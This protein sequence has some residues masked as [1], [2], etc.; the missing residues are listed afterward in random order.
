MT[1]ELLDSREKFKCAKLLSWRKIRAARFP[2]GESKHTEP[3]SECRSKHT[4]PLSEYERNHT[5][6]LSE[7]ESKH[8]EPLSKYE[9]NHTESLSCR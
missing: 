1:S 4:E 2:R 6:P 3:L 7:Y 9:S 8:T 5:E